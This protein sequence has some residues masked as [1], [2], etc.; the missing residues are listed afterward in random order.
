M[1]EDASWGRIRLGLPSHS[2]AYY[3][4]E[5]EPATEPL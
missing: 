5:F 4:G 3:M 1:K 2:I